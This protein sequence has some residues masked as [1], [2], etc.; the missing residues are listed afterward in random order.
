MD[1]LSLYINDEYPIDERDL[2]KIEKL[3]GRVSTT[4]VSTYG[5][6]GWPYMATTDAPLKDA[7]PSH[8]TCA[9]ILAALARLLCHD[10]ETRVSTT[11]LSKDDAEVIQS[12][13]DTAEKF[14]F[15]SVLEG[16]NKEQLSTSSRSY[17]ANDIFT[18]FWLTRL[19]TS[20]RDFPAD[21]ID[22][23]ARIRA[24]VQ[25]RLAD[26]FKEDRPR[27]FLPRHTDI[28]ETRDAVTGGK[29]ATDS[30]SDP[31]EVKGKEKLVE[32]YQVPHV[33]PSLRMVQA[34][35]LFEDR[36]ASEMRID[37]TYFETELHRQLSVSAI[38]DSRFDPAELVFALEGMLICRRDSVERSVFCRVIDVLSSIQN[39]N[40]YWRPVKPFMASDQGAVLAPVSVEV[41]N[42]LLRSC[43]AFDGLDLH[44]TMTSRAIPLLRRYWRW[45]EGR[46][47]TL[48]V[49]KDDQP[50][51]IT[52]WHSEH[53]NSADTIH[54]WET[55][56]V[57]EFLLGY[58][59]T[60]RAHVG[61][62][63]LVHS[64]FSY[65]P[66]LVPD[67]K[68]KKSPWEEAVSA[69]GKT[70]TTEEP[71]SS[72][73]PKL[74]ILKTLGDMVGLKPSGKP[75]GASVLLYGPPG[76]GKSTT[77][78]TLAKGLRYP[79]I[80]ITVSDFLAGG[81][82]ELESRAKNIF[83]VLAHQPPSVILFDEI[84]NFLL[85]R[86]SERYREQESTFQ[87]MTPG[88]LT[89]I[90]DLKKIENLVFIIAT[91]YEE[92]VDPAIKRT[93]RIDARLLLLP[94]DT[95][96]R[97][98]FAQKFL[99]TPA[100]TE[101]EEGLASVS[102]LLG[103]GDFEAIG[104]AGIKNSLTKT[105]DEW[106][107]TTTLESYSARFLRRVGTVEVPVQD[108]EA[109]LN[110]FFCLLVLYFQ[111][112]KTFKDPQKRVITRALE[113]LQCNKLSELNDE[114]TSQRI[115]EYAKDLEGE[116]RTQLLNAL[117]AGFRAK[118]DRTD[119]PANVSADTLPSSVA[120]SK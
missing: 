6:N 101:T 19:S 88:M 70:V 103:Y 98:I 89:K 28:V 66:P 14:L 76:T 109:P 47:T 107:R 60:L 92:R 51:D 62:T 40:P 2:N 23:A 87:F 42:S 52:G 69:W 25:K 41:A 24:G 104:K 71:V 10:G 27:P 35:E 17:G 117:K 118:P 46:V 84:D 74:A 81:A 73:G 72:L 102:A 36:F 78:K 44:D 111:S 90:S 38:P 64:K 93:G 20:R 54:L 21:R 83:F 39:S 8:S 91:N 94:P 30:K 1:A 85:D 113:I 61:R 86:D 4:F 57:L 26:F 110:E 100:E 33:F 120:D 15:E 22:M 37:F 53:V 108:L 116:G 56:Q 115:L 80:S 114:K 12:Y 82:A 112:K 65:I 13:F 48:S 50:I 31:A 63:A 97:K 16:T 29:N 45:I 5:V 34:A 96:R 18:L 43:A 77:A 105:L 75:T 67:L 55:S 106:P 9:M 11:A 119:G 32:F 7:A 59:A 3:L 58:G 99:P 68:G 79:M 95:T 49:K